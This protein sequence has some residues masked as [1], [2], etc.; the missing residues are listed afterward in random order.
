MGRDTIIDRFLRN[1]EEIGGKPALWFKKGQTWQPID[2]ASYARQAR[3]FAGALIGEGY[4][5]GDCVTICSYNCPQWVIADV[6]AMM[7]Q[8][9]PAGIYQ[10]DSAAQVAYI[11]GHCEAKVALFEDEEQYRKFV[12][13][14]GELPRVKRVV[15]FRDAEKI[16]DP[17]VCSFEMFLAS[18]Q[19]HAKAVD[20]RIAAIQDDDLAT[21]IYTSGTTG[22]P[23]GVMLSHRNLAFTANM[24][25]EVINLEQLGG[26]N[27]VVSYLPLSHIAEQMFTIHLAI[28]L[29]YSAWFA[30]SLLQLKDA[31]VAARPTLFFAVPRVWEKFHSTLENR[32]AEASFPK[33]AIVK[34][35]REV[36]REAGLHTIEY[37][38]PTGA[39]GLKYQI[40]D[41][42]F[43]SKL[44]GQLGLDRLKIAV[45]AA[46]PIGTDVL[47]FFLS[48]GI[49]IREVYGQSEDCGPTTFNYP[50]PGKTRLGTVGLALPGLTMKIAD[51][52]EI[53]AR[54]PNVFMGYYKDP[55][56]T[57]ETLIDGW[58]HSGD[59]GELDA[60][61]FL[62]ITD[63]KKNI[64]ITSGGKNVAPQPI[65][66]ALKQIDGIGQAVVIGDQRK[67]LSALLTL[68]PEQAPSF[69]ARKGWPKDL[70]ALA[71]HPA[72]QAHVQEHIDRINQDLAR[73]E[74]IKKF[75]VLAEEFTEET[76]EL[77][78]TK[79][80]KRRAVTTRRSEQIESMYT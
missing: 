42:L 24:A 29:G 15:L 38:P 64:I 5:P 23:K 62:R 77:T 21:L 13:V 52:G 2:W 43:F 30:E 28:T 32:L 65:E 50:Q 40:A 45:S 70:T 27:A 4:E 71:T 20:A 80:I 8:G 75:V 69:A 9:V 76:G 12:T 55:E 11:I 53:L 46:A 61:G 48:C 16:S 31:L 66:N 54:G 60:Q 36:G 73:V 63:R 26:D 6:G 7:A 35:A 59:I 72:F 25:N 68:D 3:Q 37:G 44:A 1:A 49:I 58:L 47:E 57:A 39:L 19:A 79:K 41:K 74:T 51:D 18:G 10:T 14:R 78:S 34:W 17:L 33:S 22:P 67:F 56:A